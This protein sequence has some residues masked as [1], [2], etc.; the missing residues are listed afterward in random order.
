MTFRK[1]L[2]KEMNMM[3]FKKILL[4][5][6]CVGL[7]VVIAPAKIIDGV[8]Y[9]IPQTTIA[10]VIDGIEDRVWQTL[11]W[12]FQNH[13]SN[14]NLPPDD[15][16]DLFGA[17]KLM[18]DDEN[19][20]GLFFA[21]DE[22]PVGNDAAAVDWQ[23]N[24]VEFYS[25]ADNSKDPSNN[26]NLGPNDQHLTFRHEYIDNE[27]A[28]VP[29]IGWK[30]GTNTTGVEFKFRDDDNLV[31]YW[32]EFK[33]PLEALFIAPVPNSLIG[34]EWQQNDNDGAGRDH[35]SK[36]WLAQGD[37]SWQWPST[38]GTAILSE[39]VASTKLEI[40]KAPAG[41]APTV[42][43]ELDPIFTQGNSVTQ[44]HHGNGNIYPTD[45]SDAFVRTY[46]LYDEENLYGYFDVYDDDP[47]GNDPAAVDWQRNGV[48]LYTDADNSKDPSGS[49]NLGPND[50]HLVFRHEFIGNEA[51]YVATLGWKA[52][53]NTTGVEFKITD[54]D[55]GYNV[56]FKIPLEALFI[57]P[58]E[59]SD[60]G[61]ELQMNDNDGNGREHISKWWLAQGDSSWQWPSTWGT[62]YLGSE[63]VVG[64]KDRPATVA[65]RFSL[66]QNYPNPFNP[67]TK[68]SYTLRS[69]GN[70]R[71]AVYDVMGR[72]V[73]V[74]VD[75]VQSAGS[76]EVA[77]SGAGLPSGVY[78]YKLQTANEVMTKKMALVR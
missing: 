77:F 56:E 1:I 14:G 21:Q 45:F 25:D 26:S 60:I 9:E 27:A 16:A 72:E 70:V 8:I 19:L 48:E 39:R 38:W 67:S 2:L 63:L 15:W 78:F 10:P 55:L 29:N 46:V 6:L 62:A 31:G 53:T 75:G 36:W 17:S 64:V 40:K 68:I 43:G 71:L 37:S 42:D 35:I 7:F 65:N 5:V 51:T 18:W 22:D 52:G 59:G 69:N 57:A 24:G 20:Y 23:R 76:H 32:L 61:F 47:V 12:N 49:S 28:A 66:A 34:I 41:T 73:V 11:D 74:L 33:I 3:T 4:S 44:N 58:V 54:D 50:Q 30:A 13:Y